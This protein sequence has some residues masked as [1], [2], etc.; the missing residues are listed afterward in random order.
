MYAKM[1]IMNSRERVLAA[2]QRQVPDQVP[3][4]EWFVHPKVYQAILPGTTWPDLRY[5][6]A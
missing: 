5:P 2:L 4:L 3:I 6:I 1:P